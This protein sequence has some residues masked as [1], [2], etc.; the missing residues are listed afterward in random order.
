MDQRKTFKESSNVFT[1]TAT[2]K[3]E[4]TAENKQAAIEKVDATEPNKTDTDM[5]KLKA[6]MISAEEQTKKAGALETNASKT[7]QDVAGA[8][9]AVIMAAE[10]EIRERVETL[11][12]N[13]IRYQDL[14]VQIGNMLFLKNEV[15]NAYK[16]ATT[17]A[18]AATVAEKAGNQAERAAW[19]LNIVA[20]VH[21]DAEKVFSAATEAK[22]AAEGTLKAIEEYEGAEKKLKA[23]IEKVK[24]VKGYLDTIF[25]EWPKLFVKTFT[26]YH[27]FINSA[28]IAENEWKNAKAEARKVEV[29]AGNVTE[30]WL[31]KKENAN[32]NSKPPKTTTQPITEKT[33]H[34]T[35][36]G[37]EIIKTKE[38]K[39]IRDVQLALTNMLEVL[40]T[41]LFD[42]I[43]AGV[44][45]LAEAGDLAGAGETPAAPGVPEIA[46]PPT[47]VS[48]AGPE[49]AVEEVYGVAVEAAVEATA[50]AAAAAERAAEVATQAKVA[51]EAAAKAAAGAAAAAA[52]SAAEAAVKAEAATEAARAAVASINR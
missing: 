24:N 16:K 23:A 19:Y 51:A 43:V 25:F 28:D 11:V 37:E 44:E 20:N 5:K 31:I 21:N 30:A 32:S 13:R 8:A 22:T 40:K 12:K 46:D 7:A 33:I 10:T 29:A 39:D 4:Q 52:E 42:Q 47:E 41:T 2:N 6:L 35:G 36:K 26:A 15:N 17:A 49:V 45:E 50:R 9:E 14:I 34:E 27:I 48:E 38:R 1:A 18:K 3:E